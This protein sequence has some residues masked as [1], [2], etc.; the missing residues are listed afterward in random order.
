MRQRHRKVELDYSFFIKP[1][2]LLRFQ[3]CSICQEAVLVIFDILIINTA[4]TAVRVT[5]VVLIEDVVVVAVV[6]VVVAVA[7]AAATAATTTTAV[8]I[9]FIL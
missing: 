3:Y 6:V 9:V 5:V 2:P 7:A 4:L 1:W 8:A